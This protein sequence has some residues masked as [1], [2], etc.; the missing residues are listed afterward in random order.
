M[1]L[2][3]I[4]VQ[5]L[6]MSFAASP[7]LA[8]TIC[9]VAAP[10]FLAKSFEDRVGI[11]LDLVLTGHFNSLISEK[12]GKRLCNAVLSFEKAN[13]LELDSRLQ[14][15]ERN[16]LSKQANQIISAWGLVKV[17]HPSGLGTVFV[18]ENLVPNR[19]FTPRGLAFES[20]DQ[21]ISV[22]FSLIDQSEIGFIELYKKLSTDSRIRKVDYKI[23]QDRAFVIN[24][25]ASGKRFYSR[26]LNLVD[27]RLGF[28]VSWRDD[29]EGGAALSAF[30]ANTLFYSA[31][32]A[33]TSVIPEPNSARMPAQ[34]APPSDNANPTPTDKN[35]HP[36]YSGSGFFVTAD[37]SGIT[38]HHVVEG[39]K[40]VKI[41]GHGNATV[42]AT[43]KRN[44][45]A[46]LKM[47]VAEVT[48]FVGFRQKSAQLG[49]QT[50]V[51]GFP[52]SNTLDNGLNFTIG[53]VS[54][55][56]GI[57][58]DSTL[59]QFTA[60]IQPGNSG[61]PIVDSQGRLIGV[62]VAKLADLET[63]RQSGQLPQNV[64]FGIKSEV[65]LG[66]LALNGVEVSSSPDATVLP[67]T[68]IARIGR[69]YAFQV[70]CEPDKQ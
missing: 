39:C 27:K 20:N 38:N 52:L 8:A 57:G 14:P 58:G 60:P 51:L 11:Q 55:L 53:S 48:S 35:T 46:L 40:T 59:L 47:S 6:L 34:S 69:S 13:G 12:Y 49:E 17:D 61:G 45:L 42:I 54:S 9:E 25:V 66:F 63:L 21:S 5:A 4:C 44:D 43:D 67:A 29:F 1:R 7:T 30:M 15:Y 2:L 50:F 33:A 36:I 3:I 68:D 41:N 31:S 16:I 18:P 28:T 65:A 56:A 10:E 23:I 62:T 32:T 37:G 24:G 64:N 26:Y 70:F 19:A 22:D